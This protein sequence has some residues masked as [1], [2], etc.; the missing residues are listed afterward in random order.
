MKGRQAGYSMIELV[1][2]I[3]ILGILSIF[4]TMC[5]PSGIMDDFQAEGFSEV[6]I[7]DLR[8]TQI[9]AMSL[10]ER[11]RL[12]ITATSYQIQ[13]QSGPVIHPGTGQTTVHYPRGV[14]IMP[15]TTIEFDALGRPYNSNGTLLS[16]VM[17]FSVASGTG[18][19]SVSVYPQTGF[20][21]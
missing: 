3:V 4:V 17:Q 9:L 6:F 12:N 8:L 5:Q 19:Q 20:V 16:H 13:N 15:I 21:E 11:Y 7:E 2:T 1:L 10:N 14:T 18:S